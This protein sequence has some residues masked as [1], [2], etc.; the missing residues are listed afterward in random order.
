MRR[1]ANARDDRSTIDAILDT[2][3]RLDRRRLARSGFGHLRD[4]RSAVLRGRPHAD[5]EGG[6]S[7]RG[8]SASSSDFIQG[9]G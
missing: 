7:S 6:E 3:P 5:T 1:Y 9:A 8:L 4:C 2:G